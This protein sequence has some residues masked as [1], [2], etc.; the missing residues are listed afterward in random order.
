MGK[1]DS[2]KPIAAFDLDGTLV[3]EHLLFMLLG[4][5][6]ELKIFSPAAEAR[7]HDLCEDFN[8]R[9]IPH[10]EYSDALVKMFD[11]NIQGVSVHHVRYAAQR[12]AR[13]HCDWLYSF[14]KALLETVKQTHECI[15]IT[16][17]IKEVVEELAPYWG[18]SELYATEMCQRNDVYTGKTKC[19]P[20]RDKSAVLKKH[21]KKYCTPF[22]DSIAVGDTGSDIAMLAEVERPIAFNPNAELAAVAEKRGWPIVVERKD[23]IYVMRRTGYRRFP[24]EDAA[25]AVDFILDLDRSRM[26]WSK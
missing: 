25:S 20:L 10:N 11:L 7:F 17:A 6:F 9:K 8:G 23:C 2:P 26:N 14:T 5:F 16:G 15:T 4:T 1:T 21:M 24:I 3:R 18:F 19:V 13:L 22:R 12:V